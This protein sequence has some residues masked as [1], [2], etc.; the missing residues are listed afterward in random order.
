MTSPNKPNFTLPDFEQ[1]LKRFLAGEQLSAGEKEQLGQQ[2]NH[3]KQQVVTKLT[4]LDV[5]GQTPE[6]EAMM[7]RIEE[8]LAIVPTK[9]Q[10]WGKDITK[11]SDLPLLYELKKY[12]KVWALKDATVAP[13]KTTAPN[14]PKPKNTAQNRQPNSVASKTPDAVLQARNAETP[15][16]QRMRNEIID[17]ALHLVKFPTK[18]YMESIQQQVIDVLQKH[19]VLPANATDTQKNK[20]MDFLWERIKDQNF[21]KQPRF[22]VWIGDYID[23][24]Y[25]HEAD[26]AC[27][28]ISCESVVT[29][30][31]GDIAPFFA[32][33]PLEQVI[34]DEA[35]ASKYFHVANS[36]KTSPTNTTAPS[37]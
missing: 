32:F 8:H 23:W 21:N 20:V 30:I 11:M 7:K 37:S 4:I 16:Q 22:K 33:P 3:L 18:P 29:S 6:N 17:K 12:V 25:H 34:V 24:K 14:P 2:A 31:K 36:T 10:E 26:F 35:R 5:F 1:L 15:N 27:D 13:P 9:D 19:A 28:T